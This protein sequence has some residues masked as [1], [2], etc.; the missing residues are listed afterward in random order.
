[1]I[2]DNVGEAALNFL[3]LRFYGGVKLA[4]FCLND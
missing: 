1:L 4:A 2:A 3:Q